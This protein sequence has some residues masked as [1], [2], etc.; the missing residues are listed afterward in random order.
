MASEWPWGL[1]NPLKD[2][3][4]G[5]FTQTTIGHPPEQDPRRSFPWIP[6]RKHL[7][8]FIL[9]ETLSWFHKILTILGLSLI[10]QEWPAI[11]IKCYKCI[12]LTIKHDCFTQQRLAQLLP[13][14]NTG[15]IETVKQLPHETSKER[16]VPE[17]LIK[18]FLFLI[19]QFCKGKMDNLSL[20]EILMGLLSKSIKYKDW[21][22]P[23]RMKTVLSQLFPVESSRLLYKSSQL[24]H[25]IVTR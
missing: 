22:G 13:S 11:N 17:F 10:F 14:A 8:Y 16:W 20:G 18:I 21:L 15:I 12:L 25:S 2:S 24:F 4:F 5:P 3:H 23:T 7:D 6:L 1:R 19:Q 9:F